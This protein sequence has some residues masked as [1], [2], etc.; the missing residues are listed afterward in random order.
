MLNIERGSA[1]SLL[2]VEAARWRR[3]LGARTLFRQPVPSLP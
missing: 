1:R 3:L 2:T